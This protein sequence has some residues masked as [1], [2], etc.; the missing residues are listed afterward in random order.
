M[1][2]HLIRCPL[3]TQK[4]ISLI[5]AIFSDKDE[6]KVIQSLGRGDAQAFIDKTDKV[7]STLF[8]IGRASTKFNLNFHSL[9]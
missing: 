2:K 5:T 3:T 4:F 6:I 7:P 8:C 1:W 9:D